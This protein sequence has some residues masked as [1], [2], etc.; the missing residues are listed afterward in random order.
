MCAVTYTVVRGDSWWKIKTKA[1]KSLSSVL[2]VNK[3]NSRTP[4]MVGKTICLPA[5]SKVG[6]GAMPAADSS[7]C[8]VI[9]KAVR[10]DSWSR[11]AKKKKVPM[12]EL[13]S[14]NGATTR[15]KILIGDVMCLPKSAKSATQASVGLVLPPP[16]EVFSANRSKAIIREVFPARL[17]AR[18]LE[19]AKR[20]SRFN[21]A[22]YNW[23][24][25]GLFQ[26][27]WYS[28]AKWLG[29]MGVTAPEMLLDAE[30]NAQAAYTLYKRAG[31]WGPWQ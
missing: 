31:G 17:E 20:E 5:G 24:C 19:I 10:G 3:A 14:A 13:L 30:V 12:S 18:A 23:C 9:Y 29:D 27:N 11:I 7:T 22:A 26:I 6:N 1:G 4:L 28:H 8:D 21:A 15:T 25:V 16:A 2:K